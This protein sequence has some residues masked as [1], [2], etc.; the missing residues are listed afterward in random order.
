MEKEPLP[1]IMTASADPNLKLISYEFFATP[2]Q[3]SSLFR[4][5]SRAEKIIIYYVGYIIR[6]CMICRNCRAT[7]EN[8]GSN[9]NF[10][11]PLLLPSNKT[12]ESTARILIS[13]VDLGLC[14]LWIALWG[15]TCIPLGLSLFCFLPAWFLPADSFMDGLAPLFQKRKKKSGVASFFTLPDF[16]IWG[17]DILFGCWTKLQGNVIP[18]SG[19]VILMCSHCESLVNP[20]ILPA[21]LL[22]QSLLNRVLDRYHFG[23]PLFLFLV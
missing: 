20:T 10:F 13:G 19:I 18:F 1:R 2:S 8:Q 16:I 6:L 3:S 9:S 17:S 12:M 11:P 22:P 5:P 7:M 4:Q 23:L 21:M 15:G 14:C